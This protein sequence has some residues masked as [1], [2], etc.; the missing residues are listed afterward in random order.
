MHIVGGG[1]LA[2]EGAA[3]GVCSLDDS[4]AP[5]GSWQRWQGVEGVRTQGL[6]LHKF[7]SSTETCLSHP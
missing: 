7:I 2:S 1:E 4:A 6:A 5:V 3:D